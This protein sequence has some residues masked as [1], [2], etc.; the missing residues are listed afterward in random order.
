MTRNAIEGTRGTPPAIEENS[1]ADHAAGERPARTRSLRARVL[2]QQQP[3]RQPP[4]QPPPQTPAQSQQQQP[5]PPQAQQ[6]ALELV[7]SASFEHQTVALSRPA[8]S[9]SGSEH[10]LLHERAA[11]P[12]QKR[13]KGSHVQTQRASRPT[14]LAAAAWVERQ[15]R[16]EPSAPLSAAHLSFSCCEIGSLDSD[17]ASLVESAL[18]ASGPPVRHPRS[19]SVPRR[20]S[21][22]GADLLTGTAPLAAAAPSSRSSK[23]LFLL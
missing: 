19:R 22:T 7:L 14:S 9:R 18:S 15:Q 10:H 16:E 6:S 4:L 23:V 1:A 5:Q 11:A 13:A 20:S 2:E 21:A 12:A 3:P 8:S 17:A